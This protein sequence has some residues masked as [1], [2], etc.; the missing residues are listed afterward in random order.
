MLAV[1]RLFDNLV[2]AVKFLVYFIGVPIF[3]QLDFR[4]FLNWAI[5]YVLKYSTDRPQLLYFIESVYG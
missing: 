5:F 1:N 2:F 4:V 3:V